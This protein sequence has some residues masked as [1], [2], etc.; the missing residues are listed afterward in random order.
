[1]NGAEGTKLLR[2]L[3]QQ[4]HRFCYCAIN[5]TEVYAGMRS[6]EAEVTADLFDRL[7]Y[8][9]VTFEIARTAGSLILDWRRKGR[10]L[11]KPDAVIQRS[12]SNSVSHLPQ[13]TAR[14]FRCA[15]W[16]FCLSQTPDRAWLL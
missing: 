7:E 1:M 11:E 2:Q 10:T 5:V 16:S 15:S 14:I 13:T 12:R 3:A 9:E 6:G 8:V 4:G